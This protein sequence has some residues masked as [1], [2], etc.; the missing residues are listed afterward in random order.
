MCRSHR[1]ALLPIVFTS[2]RIGARVCVCAV[3]ALLCIDDDDDVMMDASNPSRVAWCRLHPQ[4]TNETAA[5]SVPLLLIA[6]T[7]TT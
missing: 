4:P 5:A 1:I 7:S 6:I 3:R 2:S